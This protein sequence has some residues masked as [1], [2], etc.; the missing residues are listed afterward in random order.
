MSLWSLHPRS[1]FGDT[2]SLRK[3]Y[4]NYASEVQVTPNLLGGFSVAIAMIALAVSISS[5]TFVSFVE[6]AKIPDRQYAPDDPTILTD[7]AYNG[8]SFIGQIIVYGVGCLIGGT[9]SLVSFFSG[10]FA[11]IHEKR[12]SAVWGIMLSFPTPIIFAIFLMTKG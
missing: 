9:L 5:I 7:K 3:G 10:I 6:S 8:L 2:I 11:L 1:R 12:A 4:M